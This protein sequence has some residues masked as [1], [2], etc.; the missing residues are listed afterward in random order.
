MMTVEKE[1]PRSSRRAAREA[2]LPRTAAA[3]A[4][5]ICTRA[6]RGSHARGVGGGRRGVEEAVMG[7]LRDRRRMVS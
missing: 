7:Y 1:L 5:V 2:P 3:Q 4:R 6:D